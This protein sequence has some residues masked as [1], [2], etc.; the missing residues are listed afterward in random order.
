MSLSESELFSDSFP[1]P[2]DLSLEWFIKLVRQGKITSQDPK[3]GALAD[4]VEFLESDELADLRGKPSYFQTGWD[5]AKTLM[6][7]LSDPKTKDLTGHTYAPADQI[8]ES[9]R[10]LQSVMSNEEQDTNELLE[11]YERFKLL[12]DEF[13][14][15]LWSE[16]NRGKMTDLE[17]KMLVLL[18]RLEVQYSKHQHWHALIRRLV[19]GE[20]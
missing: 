2:G 6:R 1:D 9:N 13:S 10:S 16:E 7:M 3:F 17:N 11:K 12:Y 4:F 20:L 19:R 18:Q 15:Q 8:S 14:E 5:I